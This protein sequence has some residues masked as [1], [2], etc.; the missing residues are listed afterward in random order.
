MLQ[1]MQ[2]MNANT[3]CYLNSL[4]CVNNCFVAFILTINHITI[5]NRYDWYVTQSVVVMIRCTVSEGLLVVKFERKVHG[6][7]VM[8]M[9]V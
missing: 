6:S 3:N 2:K 8:L 5:I 1:I 9:R 4:C 7:S